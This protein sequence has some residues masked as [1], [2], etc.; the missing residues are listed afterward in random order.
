MQI[1]QGDIVADVPFTGLT[2]PPIFLKHANIGA[3]RPAWEETASPMHSKKTD[4]TPVL[5]AFKPLSGI[6]LTR[7]CEL[8]KERSNP[9]ILFAPVGLLSSLPQETQDQ[10]NKQAHRASIPLPELPGLGNC[11]ADLRGMASVP[12]GAVDMKKRRASMTDAAR[13]RVHASLVAFLLGRLLSADNKVLLD[14][15]DPGNL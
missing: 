2:K 12:T 3:N 6:I 11:F 9:R 10:I 7:D 13:M 14:A 8:D 15:V 5:V 4:R 1:S